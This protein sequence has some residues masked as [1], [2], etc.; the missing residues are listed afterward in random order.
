MAEIGAASVLK[1]WS[2]SLPSASTRLVGPIRTD[3]DTRVPYP[4][5]ANCLVSLCFRFPVLL[6]ATVLLSDLSALGWLV[7]QTALVGVASQGIIH[8]AS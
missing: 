2:L 5:S 3:Q 8:R 1:L 6:V 4:G 7:L